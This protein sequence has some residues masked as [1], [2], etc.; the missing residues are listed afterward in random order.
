MLRPCAFSHAKP[1]ERS[2]TRFAPD[3]QPSPDQSEIFHQATVFVR[4]R[5][6]SFHTLLATFTDWMEGATMRHCQLLCTQLRKVREVF[7]E[8]DP[9]R[10]ALTICRRTIRVFSQLSLLSAER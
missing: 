3:V 2:Q 4:L 9:L 1:R 8:L 6:T 10:C 7:S 5:G